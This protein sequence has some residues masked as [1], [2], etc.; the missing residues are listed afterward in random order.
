MTVCDY[1][2][3]DRKTQILRYKCNE[4]RERSA[5]AGALLQ[6]SLFREWGVTVDQ[7]I[8]SKNCFGKPNLIGYPDYHFNLSHSGR[9]VVCAVDQSPLGIDIEQ[10]RNNNLTVAKR[11]FHVNEYYNLR[12]QPL[13][14]QAAYFYEMWTLKESFIKAL[15]E[16]LYCPLNSFVLT[17]N[18]NKEL[19]IRYKNVPYYLKVYDIDSEYKLSVCSTNKHFEESI[20]I[21][22]IQELIYGISSGYRFL[23]Q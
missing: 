15:G 23:L 3:E 7:Q 16:G 13:T 17:P 10:I 18:S 20:N 12:N 5:A 21:I 19:F 22:D 6:Y 14:E 1:L 8:F 9:W 4:D 2:A 11:F